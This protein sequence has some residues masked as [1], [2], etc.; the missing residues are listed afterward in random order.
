MKLN[1]NKSRRRKLAPKTSKSSNEK[2]RAILRTLPDNLVFHFYE[3]IDKPS[4]QVATS[5]LDFYDKI[6]SFQT[7]QGRNSLAFHMK[8]GDFAVWVREAVGDPELA[9][10][11]SK[12]SSRDPHLKRKLQK[13]VN[14]R[15]T[16]LKETL[17][18]FSIIPEDGYI[19]IRNPCMR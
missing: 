17:L 5:L 3:E 19:T 4:G 7:P 15:I 14:Q 12:I 9:E 8:R 6:A 16:Q 11:I 13:T 1:K 2:I 18:E 10:K